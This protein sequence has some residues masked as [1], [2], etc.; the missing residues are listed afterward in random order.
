VKGKTV[1]LTGASSGI[2][3][4][5]ALALAREGA[6]LH[7][8]ARRAE[9]L[10]RVCADARSLGAQATPHVLDVRDPERFARVA[11]RILDEHGHID[12]LINNAGVGAMKTFLETTDDDWTWTFDTNFYSV[13]TALRLFLPSM[14]EHGKGT[15]VNVASLA[16]L[17]GNSLTAYTASKFAVVGLSESLVLEYGG[18]GIDIMVVCPGI[19]NTEIAAAAVQAG[20]SGALERRLV[21][22]LAK[23]GVDPEV[24][25]RD[26]VHGIRNPRFLILSPAHASVLHSFHSMF[27]NLT[28]ALLRRFA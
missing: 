6:V 23:H 28:R 12:V 24:V 5:T 19:I 26:L 1:V 22:L 18:R 15:I 14:L 21:E 8:L 9:L 4:A 20:R 13:V 16:G 27:P 2:G 11:K 7:L 10:E 25:A 3:R 17:V